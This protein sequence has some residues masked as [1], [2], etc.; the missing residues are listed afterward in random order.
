MVDDN[1][2]EVIV[3]YVLNGDLVEPQLENGVEG[4]GE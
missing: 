2:A 1:I 3:R 4:I